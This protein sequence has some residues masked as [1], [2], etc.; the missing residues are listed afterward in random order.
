MG[1]SICLLP[2]LVADGIIWLAFWTVP[3]LHSSTWHAGDSLLPTKDSRKQPARVT[4]TKT[5]DLGVCTASSEFFCGFHSGKVMQKTPSPFVY[6]IKSTTYKPCQRS[7][8]LLLACSRSL[9]VGLSNMAEESAGMFSS[10]EAAKLILLHNP[11]D[12]NGFIT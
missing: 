5:L 3:S 1:D 8:T 10:W 11:S 4:A 6:E 9:E 7:E 12:P 2:G